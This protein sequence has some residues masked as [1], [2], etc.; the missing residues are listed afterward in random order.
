M[1]KFNT[2]ATA[3]AAALFVSTGA[4]AASAQPAAGEQPEFNTVSTQS[5]TTRSAVEAEAAAELPADGQ[6]SAHPDA[7]APASTLTR[8]QVEAE[9][10]QEEA[11]K[12]EFP[13]ASGE[14]RVK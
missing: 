11:A 8:A 4:V 12:G 1:S 14:Q 3:I 9:V 7:A 10:S 6:A 5:D 13:D 2:I